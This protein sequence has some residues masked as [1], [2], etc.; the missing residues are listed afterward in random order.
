MKISK[1][2]WPIK[3]GFKQFIRKINKNIISI[4]SLSF[5]VL[6]SNIII[7]FS[8]NN[9]EATINSSYRQID[10]GVLTI[11]H[12][13]VK[14]SGKISLI[15]EE[16]PSIEEIDKLTHEYNDVIFLPSISYF[17]PTNINMKLGDEKI[18]NVSYSPLFSFE[19]ACLDTSLLY[20]GR[21]PED[22][23]ETIINRSAYNYFKKNNIDPL[24][25]IIELDY[26]KEIN[27][28]TGIEEKPVVTDYFIFKKEVTIVGVVDEFSFLSTPKLYYSY[29]DNVNYLEESVFESISDF[30]EEEISIYD[31]LLS[32]PNNSE[33]SAYSYTG[34][35]LRNK[36]LERIN[37]I[38]K[39]R[40]DQLSITSLGR[41]RTNAVLELVN[42]CS[43]GMDIFL[44]ISLLGTILIIGIISFSSYS[45]DKRNIA[46]MFAL[47]TNKDDILSSYLYSNVLVGIIS[48]IIAFPISFLFQIIINKALFNVVGISNLIKIPFTSFMGIRYL[49]PVFIV[50]SLLFII[51][52]STYIPIMFAS[53]ISIK[54]ELKEE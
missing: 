32:S 30:L 14:T 50:A 26:F 20:K 7:G 54:E 2:S 5:G 16:R 9:K 31:Y 22:E 48:L 33:A 49:Y 15:R 18:E 37:D 36:E 23:Y 44:V 29:L 8:I 1:N 3:Y 38:C 53:K 51:L 40:D 52:I 24:N 45:E 43:M 25:I 35:Y 28:L 10:Y 17:F 39:E 41:E 27:Y 12:Q 47:G 46:I 42:A 21:F 13:E 6:A 19:E 11:A 4:F 34:F